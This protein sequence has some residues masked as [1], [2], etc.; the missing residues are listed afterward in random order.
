MKIM[1]T[2]VTQTQM[3]VTLDANDFR[4]FLNERGILIPSDSPLSI[5][6]D[7]KS[8]L[9]QWNTVERGIADIETEP[10]FEEETK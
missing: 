3:G 8:V 9:V 6:A 1:T 4:D 10:Y 2:E 7:N 5:M